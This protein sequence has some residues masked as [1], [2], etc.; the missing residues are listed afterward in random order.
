MTAPS[1]RAGFATSLRNASSS[2][3]SSSQRSSSSHFPSSTGQAN[4]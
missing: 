4:Q 3:P 1:S 2:M